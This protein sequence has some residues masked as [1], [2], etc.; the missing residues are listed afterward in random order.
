MRVGVTM[1]LSWGPLVPEEQ[2]PTATVPEEGSLEA[3][4]LQHSPLLPDP[5]RS[6]PQTFGSL[7]PRSAVLHTSLTKSDL[8]ISISIHSL[9]KKKKKK[10]L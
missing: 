4:G 6:E 1:A 7:L 3:R 10:L 5:S 9:A 8:R 2:E